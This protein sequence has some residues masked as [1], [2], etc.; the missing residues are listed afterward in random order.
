MIILFL[1][2]LVQFSVAC[3]CLALSDA[4]Q[5][6]LYDAGWKAAKDPSTL[7]AQTQSY[8]G[9]CGHNKSH[10]VAKDDVFGHPSCRDVVDSKV[11]GGG[12]LMMLSCL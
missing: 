11:C 12:L 4:Q 6:T 9:C 3:A 8:F 2:F 10:Q 5:Q 1:L 7:R